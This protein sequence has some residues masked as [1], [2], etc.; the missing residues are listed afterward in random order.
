MTVIDVASDTVAGTI[1]VGG[2]PIGVAV[3][4]DETR[5]YT[6]NNQTGNVSVVDLTNNSVIATIPVGGQ[7]NWVVLNAS[8][9]RAYVSNFAAGTVSVIDTGSN[10]VL[11]DIAIARPS[12]IAIHDD[13]LYVI[14]VNSDTLTVIDTTTNGVVDTFPVGPG[15][16]QVEISPNG[17]YA[18]VTNSHGASTSVIYLG[19][20]S[21]DDGV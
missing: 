11:T 21:G 15:P 4:A 18:Y 16:A 3:N 8:G 7:P 9:S 5:L 20:G 19:G 1:P 6:A 2:R 12:G 17:H 13:R 10:T 14:G